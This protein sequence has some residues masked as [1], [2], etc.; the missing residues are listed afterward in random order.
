M[1]KFDRLIFAVIIVYLLAALAAGCFAW[2][3]CEQ[4]DGAYR[5][6]ENRL[7]YEVEELFKESRSSQSGAD[8]DLRSMVD[9]LS[10]EKY[11][12]IRSIDFL[13]AGEKRQDAVTDF[14][15][16]KSSYQMM[17]P[18]TDIV[19]IYI[20][21]ELTGYLRMNIERSNNR[22]SIL[23]VV[24]LSLLITAAFILAVLW[25]IR[26]HVI[27]PFWR[28]QDLTY[29]LSKGNLKGEIKQEKNHYF[30]DL[31]RNLS[32]L[33]DELEVK[34]KRELE[35]LRERKLLMLSLSHDIKTPLSTIQ[36]Y[37]R[38]LWQG[39]YETQ[40]KRL[41]IYQQIA[42]KC[43]EIENYMEELLTSSRED[44]VD[45]TVE[46]EEFYLR[47]L[48]ERVLS[49]YQE[50]CEIRKIELTVGTYENRLLR[51]DLHRLVEVFE[52]LFENAFKYGDG[53]RI[54][55]TFDEEDY[56]Q[57]IRVFNSGEPVTENDFV[58]LFES[59]FRGTNTHGRQGHGLGL[60]I[61][62]EIMHK[63]GGELFAQSQEDGMAFVV[64]LP[65]DS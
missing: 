51:G 21:N 50:K 54:D 1:K 40:E 14:Y 39:E 26:T 55:I 38:A 5:V 4:T 7:T 6:E 2:K 53:R 19:P 41:E 9:S 63:M 33:K 3:L 62:R 42:L 25:Y 10:L 58:H 59:F 34:K 65:L 18:I 29:E 17:D 37:N 64:V 32:L 15:R 56:C 45:I 46:W 22:M 11:R 31:E 30:G 13:P 43:N 35:L 52:N 12:A 24:E 48:L 20:D 61:A 44:I 57:L 8:T 27:A 36:L 60:Y 23:T 49:V 16:K 28:M 47:E